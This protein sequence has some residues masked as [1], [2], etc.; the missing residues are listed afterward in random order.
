[1]SYRLILFIKDG[2][3]KVKGFLYGLHNMISQ[4]KIV[5]ERTVSQYASFSKL[6]K[7]AEF[8]YFYFHLLLYERDC[9]VACKLNITLRLLKRKQTCSKIR[10]LSVQ[11][12]HRNYGN[13]LDRP[14]SELRPVV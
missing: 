14:A 7:K 9:V 3:K 12:R 4:N 6:N 1:M 8:L 13:A 2:E 5:T 10:F 11:K